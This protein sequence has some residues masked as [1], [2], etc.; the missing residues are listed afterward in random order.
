MGST[1]AVAYYQ[2]AVGIMFDKLLYHG[3]LAWLDDVLGY[4][5]DVK[6]LFSISEEVLQISDDVDR[7]TIRRSAVSS[8]S[9]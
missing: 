7:D 4:S 1:D 5:K 2:G 8:R 9:L 3:I 6:E